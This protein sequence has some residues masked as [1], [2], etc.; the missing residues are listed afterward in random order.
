M[1]DRDAAEAMRIL[2]EEGG[3]RCE[4]SAALQ[5]AAKRGKLEC[6]RVLV[7]HGA[8]MGEIVERVDGRSALVLAR[9]G[10]FEEIV[11][12]LRGKGARE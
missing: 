4:G 12:Y 9:E 10:G 7:E 6:V 3:A 11:A 8:D 1:L 5:V 2:L